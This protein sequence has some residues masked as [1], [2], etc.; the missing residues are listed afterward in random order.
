[1][2]LSLAVPGPV[3]LDA[4]TSEGTLG[5]NLTPNA[6]VPTTTATRD[7]IPSLIFQHSRASARCAASALAQ[8]HTANPSPAALGDVRHPF[9]I[10]TPHNMRK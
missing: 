10:S 5:K 2:R 6:V 1:M 9:R 3:L 7:P 8:P 4:P